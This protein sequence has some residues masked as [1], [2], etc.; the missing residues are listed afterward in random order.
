MTKIAATF[1]KLQE[2]EILCRSSQVVSVVND[3]VYIFGGEL[4]PR[5]P[6]DNDVHVVSL[7]ANAMIASKPATF[8]SPSPRVG[9]AA[10]TLNGKI[11]IFSGRGG[12]AM[13]PV[14]EHGAIWEFDPTQAKWSLISPSGQVSKDLP[15]A[16]SYHCMASDGE[17]TIYL[18]AGCPETGR[19]SDLWAFSLSRKEW[20]ELS[21]S[22]DPP[23]G[24]SSI[25]FTEHKLYRMNGFDGE[26]EQGVAWI[27]IHLEPTPGLH[28]HTC[29]MVLPAPRPEA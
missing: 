8:C 2:A 26:A 10:C 4:R 13:A 27:F 22:F 7:E 28:T 12:V 6:R 23:R 18:H 15:A 20:T 11:Y 16:R 14:E 21:P 19:L 1:Q 24:G 3:Q 17:D 5:E 29:L 9:S 25:T